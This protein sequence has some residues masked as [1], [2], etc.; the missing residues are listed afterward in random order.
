MPQDPIVKSTTQPN[1][2]WH[3]IELVHGSVGPKK[4]SVLVMYFSEM[5]IRMLIELLF[6]GSSD[7]GKLNKEAQL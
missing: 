1:I 2:H 7:F 6:L 5:L 3:N 4:R